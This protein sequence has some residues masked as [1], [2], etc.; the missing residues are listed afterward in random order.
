[1]W[2]KRRNGRVTTET[3][4]EEERASLTSYQFSFSLSL[5]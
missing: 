3:S 1:M 4:V 2:E 5:W